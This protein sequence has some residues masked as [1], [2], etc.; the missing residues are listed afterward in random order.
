M[1]CT[2]EY[3]DMKLDLFRERLLSAGV[4]CY[5]WGQGA[6][7]TVEQLFNEL[8]S[9]ESDLGI[10]DGSLVRILSVV[11]VNIFFKDG[12]KT[13]KLFE[14]EQVFAN[15]SKRVR[16]L[17]TSLSE[18]MQF[19]ETKEETLV[20]MMKEELSLIV[21]PTRFSLIKQ[22]RQ[23]RRLSKSYPG[24]DTLYLFNDYELLLNK[25]EF[26]PHGYTEEQS[27]KKTYFCWKEV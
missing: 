1:E 10:D 25:E 4:D 7:K 13:L 22:N 14:K 9:G 16:N 3:L 18:K 20:R 11:T 23:T 17:D 8:C 26:N 2:T 21:E 27:D 6:T 19:Q 15:G 5:S 12:E 24:L